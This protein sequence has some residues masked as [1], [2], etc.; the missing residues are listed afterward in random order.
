M[1]ELRNDSGALRMALALVARAAP[2]R[3]LVTAGLEY[4]DRRDAEWWPLVRLPPLHVPV[5]AI[6][7]L[8]AEQAAVLAGASQGYAWTPESSALALQIGAAPGGALLEVGFDLGALLADAAGVPLRGGV[9]LA[10]F[11]FRAAQA[12]LVRFSDALSS[13]LEAVGR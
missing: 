10:L 9:E 2:D 12:D 1:A 8:L 3:L 4:L 13:E 6:E 5:P 7:R 11:R